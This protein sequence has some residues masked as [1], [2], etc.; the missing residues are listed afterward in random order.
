VGEIFARPVAAEPLEWT[1]E[2]LTT[3]APVQVE[4]E[5]LHRYCLARE[6]C[7]NR[8]VL[9]VAAG[10]GY[11]TALLAQTALTVTGVEISPEAVAHA[12][13]AYRLPNLR[14]CEGD[15]RSIPLADASV[16]VVVSFETIEHFY[17][18]DVFLAE[19]RRVLRPG[20]LLIVSSPDRDLYSPPESPANPFHRRELSKQEFEDLLKAHFAHV[21]VLGQRPVAGSAM[22]ADAKPSA[23]SLTFEKRGPLHVEVTKGLP[24]SIYVIALASD[25]PVIGI[26]DSIYV[27]TSEVGRI[28][29]ESGNGQ[30]AQ[31]AA[32]AH[33]RDLARSELAG[34]MH[35]RDVARSELAGARHE[36][37]VAR[38]ENAAA[39]HQRDLARIAARR[40]AA[41]AEGHWR[42]QVTEAERQLAAVEDGWR[43][44]LADTERQ[45]A[46]AE[47]R[48]TAA[49]A[50]CR[51]RL[52]DAE[53]RLSTLSER[54]QRADQ[55]DR[56]LN[57]LGIRRITRLIPLS[58][59]R[60]LAERLFG[61]GR[62]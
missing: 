54:A 52:T 62:Q 3:T 53:Q 35:E 12:S 39:C 11:G 61:I 38:S 8:D 19:V 20:G 18:H 59:R 42:G 10:E 47:Q 48:L 14:F 41:A 1:G 57:R 4:V 33:E 7:R 56:L 40:A 5:H 16:D 36:R 27:E 44:R 46:N 2:R 21:R 51:A 15:A 23:E 9:D 31:A 37:D 30:S 26:P 55:Y 22:I 6:L 50:Q 49:E 28:L 25:S 45:L 43:S 13:Q 60:F 34:A 17:E 24:R 32:M 29:A 58:G